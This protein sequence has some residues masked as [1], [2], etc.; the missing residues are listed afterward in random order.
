MMNIDESQPQ[1][2]EIL[3]LQGFDP[4]W[5]MT[6]SQALRQSNIAMGNPMKSS[7]FKEKMN[8]KQ[9]SFQHAMCELPEDV[10]IKY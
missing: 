2:C 7:C 10:G 6:A 4:P 1:G 3:G 9:W 8:G 5:C